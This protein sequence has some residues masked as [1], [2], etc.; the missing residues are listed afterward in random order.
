MEREIPLNMIRRIAGSYYKKYRID[1][2]ELFAEASL[3]Y[4]EAVQT[5][6]PKYGAQLSTWAYIKINKAL[7]AFVKDAFQHQP[8]EMHED[9]YIWDS[10]PISELLLDMSP[11]ARTMCIQIFS[12]PGDYMT[13]FPKHARGLLK[14]QFRSIGWRW[15]DIYAAFSEIKALLNAG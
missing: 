11:E 7:Q 14:A 5:Y 6:D 8:Y 10:L 12:T 13:I 2:N 1:F 15:L 9:Q 3:A 4:C